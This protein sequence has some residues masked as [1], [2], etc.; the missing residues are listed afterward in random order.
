MGG[1]LDVLGVG[2]CLSLGSRFKVGQ[3]KIQKVSMYSHV[4]YL[5]IDYEP[6]WKMP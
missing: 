6:F 1:D 5:I 2:V 3:M 4:L